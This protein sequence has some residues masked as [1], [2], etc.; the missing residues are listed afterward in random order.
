[1]FDTPGTLLDKIR[2]GEDSFW[3]WKTSALTGSA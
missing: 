2:L 3:N 1:M